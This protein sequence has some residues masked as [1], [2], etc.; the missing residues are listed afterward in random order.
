[1]MEQAYPSGGGAAA[2]TLLPA[3]TP[4]VGRAEELAFLRECYAA[5]A[6]GDGG[7]VLLSGAPGV[8]KT[9]LARELGAHAQERG[10]AFLHGAYLREGGTPYEPW[11]EAL[12]SALRG[13]SPEEVA[14]LLGPY[15]GDLAQI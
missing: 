8:G 6:G 10:G 2:A 4:L 5:A 13:R 3:R 11:V 12:R 15:A 14:P 9:R 7:L 1:M